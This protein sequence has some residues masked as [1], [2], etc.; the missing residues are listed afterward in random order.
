ML[1]LPA[2]MSQVIEFL[3]PTVAACFIQSIM[4]PTYVN[5]ARIQCHHHKYTRSLSCV[6]QLTMA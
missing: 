2:K 6:L 5:D 1:I 3:N 4:R